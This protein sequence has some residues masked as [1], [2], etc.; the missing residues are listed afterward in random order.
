MDERSLGEK[1]SDNISAFGGSWRFILSGIGFIFIWVCFNILSIFEVIAWDKYPFILLNL[2]LSLI[3]AFQAPFI[4]MSQKRCE[5]KQD[6]IYRSLFREIKE[7]VETD[8]SLE[9]EIVEKNKN[10]EEEIRQVKEMLHRLESLQ[11]TQKVV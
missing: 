10:L 7:L 9:Y 6:Q 4:L 1:V 2:F 5:V 8:L 11:Q 3:A